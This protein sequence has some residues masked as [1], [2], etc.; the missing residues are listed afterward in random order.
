MVARLAPIAVVLGLAGS[1]CSAR[2]E[3]ADVDSSSA[4]PRPISSASEGV[5]RSATAAN[6]TLSG[7]TEVFYQWNFADPS[8]GI[9][10]FR[11]F[12]NRHDTFTIANTVIDA[13]AT[14]SATS[15]HVALQ[16]GHT[17]ET[18]YL[19]EPTSP[20]TG[21][22]GTTGAATWKTLQQANVGYRAPLGRGALV[23]AGLFLSPIG[24][25]GMAVKEQW[26][27]SR[28][29]LFFGLPFYHTGARVSYGL[30]DRVTG[31]LAVYNGWNSV[32]DNNSRK[33]I[34]VQ[35]TYAVADRVTWNV[36]YFGGVERATAS[37]EGRPW[38]H[39]LDS[40]VAWYPRPELSLLV[41]GDV[42]FE[43][44]A[45]GRSEWAA[46]AAYLRFRARTWLYLAGRS[47][48]F[49][50]GVAENVH[51]R[52]SAIFWPSPHVASQ[53]LTCDVRPAD[54]VS[55]RL[56]Y[57]HDR[58]DDPMFFDGTVDSDMNGAFVPNASA[59]NTLTAGMTT[60]F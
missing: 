7:L 17:P 33:S 23:E 59:Q 47:D 24:P 58:A 48:L 50:E 40:Y 11:G 53:T 4:T 49:W 27:W 16:F 3:E 31:A 10:N 60:W 45:F 37:P 15:A 42:G 41:H 12:D 39:L 28:S 6:V 44:N 55:F 52:S 14:T 19:A 56:E 57:R 18:Y 32:V 51:G 1:T 5:T 8:N 38:R 43:D 9:T 36:L 26:N 46:G 22:A 34:A 13:S 30:T 21:A 20:G 29:N 25:E 35:A 2:A 54:N